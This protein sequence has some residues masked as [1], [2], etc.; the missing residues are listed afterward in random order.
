MS[1]E[2]WYVDSSAL[3][4]TV[5]AEPESK[6]LLAWLGDKRDLVACEL[7]RVEVVRAVR[8]SDPTAVPRA[9]LAIGTLHLIRLDDRL[10]E[11]AS[12]LDPPELRSLD[13]IHLAAA[14]AL[15]PDL[16]GVVTYDSRM[17]AAARVLGL[18]V[19]SPGAR[20]YV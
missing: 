17:L 15:G 20:E 9:L 1:A 13:A 3:V 19:A 2:G 6:A 18:Q 4:K 11:H 5:I 8:G 10:L 16:A 14:L 12:A 7:V